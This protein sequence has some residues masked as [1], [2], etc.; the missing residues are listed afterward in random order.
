MKTRLLCILILFLVVPTFV[1]AEHEVIDA[2]CTLDIKMSLRENARYINYKLTRNEDKKGNV[3]YSI[4]LFNITEDVN[5]IN[6][7]DNKVYT[8]KS[9]VIS[10]IKPGTNV[11]LNV[12]A[13]NTTYCNGYKINVLNINIPYYNPYSK[14]KLC[15]GNEDYYLCRE[16]VLLNMSQKEFETRINAYIKEKENNNNNNEQMPDKKD[17]VVEDKTGFSIFDF[18]IKYNKA[19][20]ITGVV[21]LII[22]IVLDIKISKKKRE[23]YYEKSFNC[24]IYVVSCNC[25]CR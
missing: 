11:V 25:I 10:N 1:K 13:N 15:V 4:T 14:N 2:R 24:I 22:Y 12:N 23:V 18:I 7:S 9:N 6:S 8:I 20:S 21:L 5:V 16:N 17:D 19:I 3:T